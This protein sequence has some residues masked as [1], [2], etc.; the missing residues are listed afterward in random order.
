M[1]RSQAR[2]QSE[3]LR[4]SGDG[5]A[6]HRASSPYR[7][8]QLLCPDHPTHLW[9]GVPLALAS[10]VLFGAVAPLSKLLLESTSPFKLV[11]LMY[12]GAGLGLA[13]YRLLRDAD[14]RR[15]HRSANQH[16]RNRRRY[17]LGQTYDR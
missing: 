9:P 8:R 3:A 1:G 5:L 12:F 14:Q 10:A 11:G 13:A 17:G 15:P 4:P 2:R 16:A 7:E 6:A